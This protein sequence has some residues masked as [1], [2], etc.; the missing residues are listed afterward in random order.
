MDFTALCIDFLSA[1]PY[2]LG[3]AELPYPMADT[4]Y[5]ENTNILKK[6]YKKTRARKLGYKKAKETVLLKKQSLATK[7]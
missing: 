7:N 3:M 5:M 2:R 6:F 4:F 1:I